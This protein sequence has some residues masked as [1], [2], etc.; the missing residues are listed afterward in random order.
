MRAH[1]SAFI[2]AFAVLLGAAAHGAAGQG[3]AGAAPILT[4][5]TEQAR[6]QVVEAASGLEFPWSA[7][8]APGGDILVT[9]LPGRL[10]IIRNGALLPAPVAGLPGDIYYEADAGLMD[11]VLDPDFRRNRTLYLSYAAGDVTAN[12]LEVLRARMIGDRLIDTKV[13][14]RAVKDKKGHGPLGGRLLFLPDGALMVSV[15]DG[16]DVRE[17]AQNLDSHL[18]SFVR[19]RTDGAPVPDNPLVGKD[20]ARP[21]IYSWGH[22]TPQGLALRPAT[23]EV[24]SHEHGPKGG[25]EVNIIKPGVNYG[26]PLATYGVAY[27]GSIISEHTEIAGTRQPVYYWTPSIAPSGMAFYEGEAFPGWKDDLLI[28]ALAG[29]HL[30]RLE[31]DG[32]RVQDGEAMLQDLAARIRDVRVGPDGLVYL[33]TDDLDG[34]LLRVEPAR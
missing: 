11:V 10:R 3:A 29:Q 24:W 32:D 13:I 19:I 34:R 28:G 16:Y 9:E 17:E 33:L 23:Q 18:G 6:I 2:P 12:R 25:D 14:F 22:R 20:N 31:L 8:F 15:G 4:E 21:E 7:A 1:L 27:D 30:H 5:E 26:W